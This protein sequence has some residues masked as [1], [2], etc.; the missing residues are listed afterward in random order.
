M[1]L[2]LQDARVLVVASRSGLGAAVARRFSLEGAR[3]A[4]NGRDADTLSETASAIQNESG[5]TVAVLPGDL[6]EPDAAAGLV[7]SAAEQLGGLDILVTNAGGPPHGHF[8]DLTLD[9]WA[10]GHKS[11]LLS[12][13]AMVQ[14]ALP[15]L[16]Q[17]DRA[18][19]LT[20]TSLSAK[21]AVDGLTISNTYRAGIS[22]L[23][24][25]LANDLG[26]EGIRVNAILPGWTATARVEELLAARAEAAG[27]SIEDERAARTQDIPLKRVGTPE[28]FGNV[29]VFIASPAASFVHGAM[30][31]VDGGEIK[32][33]L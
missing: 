17:S 25:T 4:I 23:V 2:G 19:I 11:L 29:A 12:V 16:R 30:I 7:Q 32:A 20:I 24:K 27:T 18:S 3:V 6:S 10:D 31:P 28:H 21:Q 13:V 9:Q 14:A 8:V 1:D 33:N 5:N 15:F 26:P 22:G